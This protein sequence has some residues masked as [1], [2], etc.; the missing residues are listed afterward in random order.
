LAFLLILQNHNYL[1]HQLILPILLPLS[2]WERLS[3][4]LDNSKIALLIASLFACL[5]FI[6]SI[7]KLSTIQTQ[8]NILGFLHLLI[9]INS[10]YISSLFFSLNFLESFSLSINSVVGIFFG[11]KHNAQAETGQSQGHLPA[12]SIQIVYLILGILFFKFILYFNISI[13]SNLM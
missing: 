1:S 7:I 8:K 10:K 6:S 11:L 4:F 9:S 3:I 5:I 12:S 2:L 13:M